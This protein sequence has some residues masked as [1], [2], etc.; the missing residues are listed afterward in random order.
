MEI[1]EIEDRKRFQKLDIE[2]IM[3]LLLFQVRNLWRVDGLYFLGIEEKFGTNLATEIDA[4]CWSSLAKIEAKELKK[5]FGLDQVESVKD[6]LE[7]LS[8]TSWALYQTKKEIEISE[9]SGIFRVVSCKIQEARLKKGLQI[10]PCKK[11]RFGYLKSFVEELNKNFEV[12][13]K[14]CPPDLKPEDC[15]CEWEFRKK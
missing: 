5:I 15:W 11:V 7:L 1:T 14:F 4:N 12:I 10:F 8:N 9:N 6:L 3:D 13:C 2:K